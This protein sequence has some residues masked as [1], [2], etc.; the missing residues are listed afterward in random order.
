MKNEHKL[1]NSSEVQVMRDLVDRLNKLRKAYYVD[2][3]SLVTD[4]EYDKLYNK[5]Q[6]LEKET[7]LVLDNSPT[8]KIGH[9]VI[10]QLEKQEHQNQMF[11]LD[12]TKNID[13]IY[14]W[15]EQN[16]IKSLNVSIKADG[17][18]LELIYTNGHLTQAITRGDGSIG[19]NVLH[20][21]KTI[22]NI[23]HYIEQ[24]KEYKTIAI[25]GEALIPISEF[26]KIASCDKKKS[27]FKNPRNL[28]SGSLR[29]LN[30]DICRERH[31]IFLA[32]GI[33]PIPAYSTEYNTNSFSSNL[34][35]LNYIGFSVV[36]NMHIFTSHKNISE[37]IT[38]MQSWIN[39]LNYAYDGIVF[40]DDDNNHAKQ[41]LDEQEEKSQF[42]KYPA[43]ALAYKFEDNEY[44]TTL[45]NVEWQCSR[46][47]RVNPVAI[48]EPIEIDGTTVEK[49]TL[50]N[51]LFI[52]QMLLG[53]GD[54]IV[55]RKANM[56]IPEVVGNLTNSDTLELPTH[57]P[58]CHEPLKKRKNYPFLYC[59]NPEC[60]VTNIARIDWAAGKDALNIVGLSSARIRDLINYNIISNLIDLYDLALDYKIYFIDKIG[61]IPP[62]LMRAIRQMLDIPKWGDS[63]IHN[64]LESV[65]ISTESTLPRFVYS[66]GIPNFGWTASYK[67]TIGLKTPQEWLTKAMSKSLNIEY[68]TKNGEPTVTSES[69]SEWLSYSENYDYA[70]TLGQ[71]IHCRKQEQEP[72]SSPQTNK[73]HNMVIAITGKYKTL[74]R[75]QFSSLVEANGGTFTDGIKSDTTHLLNA[76]TRP[77]NKIKEA[78][79][80]GV[81]ILTVDMFDELI[82]V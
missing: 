2:N 80:K 19:E 38:I 54:T 70:Y 66:L 11:S 20:T 42:I 64:I 53:I 29:Q 9:H 17:L 25:Y 79:Q 31:L 45:L 39:T 77:S 74:N 43:Y 76:N 73:L 26:N 78:E 71:I 63:T 52:R 37:Q 82:G 8:K 59:T 44:T 16:N 72:F 60:H 12:K 49:A 33:N 4:K 68:F 55:I 1:C 5:L 36:D 24:L 41:L 28:S 32:Y 47:G 10:S 27:E 48:F 21:A 22:T 65:V 75:K 69:L 34:Q 57:C 40:R 62:Y 81:V 56:I 50:N 18:A 6:K 67:S 14:A 13:N 3:Q 15:A 30:A 23:P 58:S 7:F 46:S 51:P 35:W 61:D